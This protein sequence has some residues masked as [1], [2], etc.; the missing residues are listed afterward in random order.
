MHIDGRDIRRLGIWF[1]MIAF[2]FKAV[3]LPLLSADSP[4]ASITAIFTLILIL[5]ILFVL[6]FEPRPLVGAVYHF[7]IRP[8]SPPIL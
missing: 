2:V 6:S 8:R 5:G 7:G 3:L 1:L 4:D